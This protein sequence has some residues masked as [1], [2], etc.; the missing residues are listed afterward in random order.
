M[1][2][3]CLGEMLEVELAAALDRDTSREE[4]KC[5]AVAAFLTP[6]ISFTGA[7]VYSKRKDW[8]GNR[9]H[10]TTYRRPAGSE[11]HSAH[12]Q[13]TTASQARRSHPL[14][15]ADRSTPSTHCRTDRSSP[16]Q[17]AHRRRHHCRALAVCM[18][19]TSPAGDSAV[20]QHRTHSCR[21]RTSSC[22]PMQNTRRTH[23]S[24]N[25][26]CMHL[27]TPHRSQKPG[28]SSHSH[29]QHQRC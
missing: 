22:C 1:L 12:R 9:H 25:P 19:R 15:N 10:C 3:H 4:P 5:A 6:L 14:D 28:R 26:A 13:L 17:P 2:Q 29:L 23:H 24:P 27:H 8:L 18:A 16:H 11:E 21:C 7:A 20:Q